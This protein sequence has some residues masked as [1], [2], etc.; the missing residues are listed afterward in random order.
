MSRLTQHFGKHARMMEPPHT[1][2]IVFRRSLTGMIRPGLQDRAAR[3]DVSVHPGPQ[4]VGC[5]R[6]K[7]RLRRLQGIPHLPPHAHHCTARKVPDRGWLTAPTD[8][9]V[10]RCAHTHVRLHRM[11][12]GNHRRL[13]ILGAQHLLRISVWPAVAMPRW[14]DVGAL[15]R[16][17]SPEWLKVHIAVR[18]PVAGHRYLPRLHDQGQMFEDARYRTNMRRG[19]RSPES[20]G[21][22]MYRM[23]LERT[24]MHAVKHRRP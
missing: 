3:W 18:G 21:D 11:R 5:E 4:A 24:P 23:P 14:R 10:S 22:P 20:G 16:W 2:Q 13:S 7:A 19:G 15:A 9:V 12:P 1:V 17:N 6:T 8:A